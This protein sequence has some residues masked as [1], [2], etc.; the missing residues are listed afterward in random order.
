M[1]VIPLQIHA[2]VVLQT[3]YFEC[4]ISQVYVH[5]SRLNLIAS[6]YHKN[7]KL[8][9]LHLLHSEDISPASRCVLMMKTNPSLKVE[10]KQ[11][12]AHEY[13]CMSS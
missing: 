5:I 7:V 10:I 3:I 12:Y 2:A 6:F 8:G 13:N 11:I 9:I 4:Y 1:T